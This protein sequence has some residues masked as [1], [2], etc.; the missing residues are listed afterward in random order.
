[1]LGEIY[2]SRDGRALF[3]AYSQGGWSWNRAQIGLLRDGGDFE[4][5]TRDANRYLTL[6]LSADGKTLATVMQRS[7]ATLSVLSNARREFGE[8]R[9][10]LSQAN[11]D[12]WASAVAW[13]VD[14]NLLF[15]NGSRL[16]KLG[17]D[18]TNQIQL[19]ADS[20]ATMFDP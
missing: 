16:L 4:P 10:L 20:T 17:A 11:E 6:S 12:L 7:Y 19:L 18:G 2:W 15:S 1:D 5:I 8:P 3:V 14:G 9:T 13:S